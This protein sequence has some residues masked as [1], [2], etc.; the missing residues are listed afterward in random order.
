MAG[1]QMTIADSIARISTS[2][3]SGSGSRRITVS[4][5]DEDTVSSNVNAS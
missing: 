1:V 2:C 5:N 3:G 4:G